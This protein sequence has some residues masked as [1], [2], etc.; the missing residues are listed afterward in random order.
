MSEVI[1]QEVI[2]NFLNG[3]DPEENIVGIEYDYR[4][5][6]IHKII[7]DPE[8]GKIIKE[9]SFVPFLW[10]GDLS[11]LNFYNKS[12]ALQKNKM[13]EHGIL[14]EKLE[15]HGNDRLENGLTYLVKSIKSYTDLIQFFKKGGVDPW[16]EENKD[17]F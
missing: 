15:T 10:V 7:Q 13:S 1:S 9:D 4:S 16:A 8:M 3:A 5:N 2:E 12:K 6:K 11:S 17:L 14:I